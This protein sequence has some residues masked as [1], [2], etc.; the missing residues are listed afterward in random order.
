MNNYLFINDFIK[1]VFKLQPNAIANSMKVAQF[2]SGKRILVEIP[3]NVT[4]T[5]RMLIE[6]YPTAWRQSIVVM[7]RII[8]FL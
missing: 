3:A 8:L 6:E 4:R 5:S 2:V 1:M 7:T